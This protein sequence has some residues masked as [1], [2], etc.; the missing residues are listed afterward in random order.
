[1]AGKQAQIQREIKDIYSQDERLR[2][3]GKA[4]WERVL[5]VDTTNRLLESLKS[6]VDKLKEDEWMYS[7][8]D[9]LFKSDWQKK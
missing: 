8:T 5:M 4:P 7:S 6:K 1:M 2:T 3:N 9:P